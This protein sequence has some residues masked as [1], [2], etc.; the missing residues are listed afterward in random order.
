M[1]VPSA[2]V[3]D[4]AHRLFDLARQGATEELDSYVSAGIPV[5]LR[6]HAGNS[7]LMLA[8]YHGHAATV[9][10]LAAHGADINRTNDDNRTP[11][12]GAVFREHR[13]VVDVL[14]DLG[15][16]PTLGTPSALTTA[17]VFGLDGLV[18]RMRSTTSR[19]TKE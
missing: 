4:L 13:A 15:A 11:L 18:D 1:S 19:M 8:A 10:A 5:N 17:R 6:D 3:V 2:S 7:L 12:A 14:L 16:S 9:H